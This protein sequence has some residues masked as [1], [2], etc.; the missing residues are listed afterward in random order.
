[1]DLDSSK[2]FLFVGFLDFLVLYDDVKIR[3][4]FESFFLFEFLKNL[5][6]YNKIPLFFN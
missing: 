5:P 3:V 4:L 1:M 6:G 2:R